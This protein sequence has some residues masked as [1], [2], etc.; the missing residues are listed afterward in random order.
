MNV[1]VLGGDGFIGSHFV[2]YALSRGCQL[3]VFGRFSCGATRNLEH[4]HNSIKLISGEFANRD[5]VAK[6]VKG[7]DIV[8]HFISTTS[9]ASSWN[10]PFIEI[11]ENIRRSVQ[12]FKI[13]SEH[14]VQKIAYVS[15]GGTVYG[16]HEGVTDENVLERPFTPYGIGKIT[17]EHFLNYYRE[18]G[19]LEA[20][21]YRV[22]NAYGP[23]QP[24]HRPQGVIAHWM[25]SILHEQDVLVYGDSKTLRDYIFVDDVAELIGQS[26]ES[27]SDS[28]T[29][30]VGS[31]QGIAVTELLAI[32]KRVIKHRFSVRMLPRRDFDNVSTIL[33]CKRILTKCPG[34]KFSNFEEKLAETWQY[35]RNTKT[36]FS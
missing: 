5:D 32:F 15:S 31:G 26:L 18:H 13:A 1:L 16:R 34:F 12:F 20:D 25:N 22:G 17:I 14:G 30:N 29:Y 4:L 28:G 35:V 11:D 27:L 23:R 2:E 3:S 7:Q 21:I 19:Q 33:D 9:P 36:I 8:Y 6:A 10:D 24:M